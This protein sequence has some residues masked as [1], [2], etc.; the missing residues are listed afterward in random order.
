MI[1]DLE[2]HKD[3]WV[4]LASPEAPDL[5]ASWDR[6]ACLGSLDRLEILEQQDIRA[7]MASV[8]HPVLQV[9]QVSLVRQEHWDQA[10][11]RVLEVSQGLLGFL[12]SKVKRVQED[13]L[14]LP[15]HQDLVAHREIPDSLDSE[16]QQVLTDREGYEETLDSAELLVRSDFKVHKVSLVLLAGLV[17]QAAVGLLEHQDSGVPVDHPASRETLATPGRRDLPELMD[18]ADLWVVWDQSAA[19]EILG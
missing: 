4:L 15:A 7:R 13:S 17:F 10:D 8:V 2:D 18:S 16:V 3:R 12:E 9:I 11:L 6:M 14:A 19:L 1:R 5:V